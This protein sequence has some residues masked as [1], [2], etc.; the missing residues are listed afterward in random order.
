MEAMYERPPVNVK[1][2]QGSTFTFTRNL[3]YIASILFTHLKCTC[4][5][6]DNFRDSGNQPEETTK[7][8]TANINLQLT[9][10]KNLCFS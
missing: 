10:D 7:T 8:A 6:T 9:W 1:V 2:E 4:V 5:R 3:P